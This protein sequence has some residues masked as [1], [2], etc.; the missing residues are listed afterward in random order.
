MIEEEVNTVRDPATQWLTVVLVF[1]VTVKC[2]TCHKLCIPN[3]VV[4]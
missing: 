1:Q 4:F 3:T 2:I